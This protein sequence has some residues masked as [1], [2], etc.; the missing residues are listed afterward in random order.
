M[1]WFLYYNWRFNILSTIKKQLRKYYNDNADERE[2]KRKQ[3]WKI[4]LRNKFLQFMKNNSIKELLEAGAGTGHDSVFFSQNGIDVTAID[5]SQNHV[6]KC[7]EKGLNA[8]VMDFLNLSF[9]DN[10][11]DCVYAMNSLLHVP[12]REIYQVIDELKRVVRNDGYLFLCQYG[13]CTASYDEATYDNNNKGSRFFSFR[14]YEY[15]K[16][17]I[18]KSSL[19]IIDSS[20]I[21]IGEA[22][23][24]SQYYIVKV[25]K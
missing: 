4:E 5:L 3:P 1:T 7:K 6:L 23:Y 14:S 16:E 24:I 10:K 9:E 25:I 12:N 20:I 17:I 22:G 13:T 2:D 19:V 15:F 11:F 8:Y 18:K 21:D